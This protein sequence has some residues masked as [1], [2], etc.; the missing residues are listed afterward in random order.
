MDNETKNISQQISEYIAYLE[1]EKGLSKNTILAYQ[2]DL[3]GFFD[4]VEDKELSDI[5]RK[6]FSSYIKFLA[7]NNI[8]P[9]SIRRQWKSWRNSGNWK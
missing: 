7:K 8:N 4:F 2:S 5:A 6:D 1:I 3:F 9:S